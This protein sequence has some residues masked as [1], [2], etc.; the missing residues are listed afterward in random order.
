MR[1]M[2]PSR[3]KSCCAWNL[4]VHPTSGKRTL[5]PTRICSSCPAASVAA[6]NVQEFVRHIWGAEL[7]WAQRAGRSSR[8]TARRKFPPGPLDA[9]FDLHQQAVEI[10]RNLLASP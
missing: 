7:R 8:N 10:F 4:R 3:L 1:R 5:T 9:L 2:L 6:A